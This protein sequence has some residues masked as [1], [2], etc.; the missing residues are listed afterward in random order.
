MI[1]LYIDFCRSDLITSGEE[2]NI[3]KTCEA[4][5]FVVIVRGI[6]VGFQRWQLWYLNQRMRN[7]NPKQTF[8]NMPFGGC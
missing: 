1:P 8:Y 3:R 7:K 6:K 4:N 5:M 2:K